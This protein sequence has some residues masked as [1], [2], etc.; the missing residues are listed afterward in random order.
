MM[1]QAAIPGELII[2]DKEALVQ[3][4]RNAIKLIDIEIQGKRLKGEQ[5]S[6]YFENRK[7]IRLK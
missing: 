1:I 3:T 2:K 7:V 5:I 6:S 4:G